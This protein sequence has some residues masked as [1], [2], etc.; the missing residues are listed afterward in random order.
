MICPDCQTSCDD[1]ARRCPA[2]GAALPEE[3]CRPMRFSAVASLLFAVVSLAVWGPVFFGTASGPIPVTLIAPLIGYG[4]GRRAVRS[5][6]PTLGRI[7]L[8]LNIAAV[9]IALG[10]LMLRASRGES[11]LWLEQ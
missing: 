11:L 5:S 6:W 7:G 9:L 8:W 10:Y 2:C 4:L 3:T 1:G